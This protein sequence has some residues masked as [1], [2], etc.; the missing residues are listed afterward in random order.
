[1]V[2]EQ[3]EEEEEKNTRHFFAGRD[4]QMTSIEGLNDVCCESKLRQC[5]RVA[6]C[7]SSVVAFVAF[8]LLRRYDSVA[9]CS[10]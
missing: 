5:C 7:D 4:S 1:M 8:I 9:S 2:M 6:A 10:R 3:E